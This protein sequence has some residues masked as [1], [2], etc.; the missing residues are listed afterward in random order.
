MSKPPIAASTSCCRRASCSCGATTPSMYP[1]SSCSRRIE[2]LQPSARCCW[3][4]IRADDRS[5]CRPLLPTLLSMQVRLM[6]P[7]NNR[8]MH[9]LVTALVLSALCSTM[10]QQCRLSLCKRHKP[11]RSLPIRAAHCS[12]RRSSLL[13][14]HCRL[15]MSS[16]R[17]L[18]S[19]MLQ[20][21]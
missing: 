7:P 16:A 6:E 18:R 1:K 3:S 10:L 12:P 2:A 14:L 20:V 15:P 9:L 13:C 5:S 17:S 21:R 4:Q 8:G 19:G 11:S